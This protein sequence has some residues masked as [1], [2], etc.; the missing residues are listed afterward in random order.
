MK[1]RGKFEIK[2][3]I[4]CPNVGPLFNFQK[5]KSFHRVKKKQ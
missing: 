2:W 4:A 3:D 1:I 5:I